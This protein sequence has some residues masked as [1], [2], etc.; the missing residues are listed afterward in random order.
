[1]AQSRTVLYKINID[2]TG[3]K[4]KHSTFKDIP[5][6]IKVV[7]MPDTRYNVPDQLPVK[8]YKCKSEIDCVS[9]KYFEVTGYI[10]NREE[11][12][13]HPPRDGDYI[14]QMEFLP[15]PN[16]KYGKKNWKSDLEISSVYFSD[17]R[18][19]VWDGDVKLHNRYKVIRENSIIKINNI[20]FICTEIL[21][22]MNS[23]IGNTE[24]I[25]YFKGNLLIKAQ[26][27]LLNGDKLEMILKNYE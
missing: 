11:F 2:S 17:R 8:Y 25:F 13:T 10:D 20:E 26:Y 5:T 16:I 1:M 23:K 9:P 3:R 27:Y 24:V 12:W 7:Y 19:A 18:W 14:K 22:K 15:F 6:F 4:D 21:A